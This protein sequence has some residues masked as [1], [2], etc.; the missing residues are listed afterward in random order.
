MYITAKTN[1]VQAFGRPANYKDHLARVY[2]K[3]A[4]PTVQ[5]P[6]VDHLGPKKDIRKVVLDTY[7]VYY[8]EIK[9]ISIGTI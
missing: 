5:Y 4:T 6:L 8:I 9:L 1:S 2:S 3:E 7:L